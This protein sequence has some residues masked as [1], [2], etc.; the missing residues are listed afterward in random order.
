MKKIKT[1]DITTS[2]A[3]PVKQGTLDHLQSA[4]TEI[5]Q[6]F[7]LQMLSQS[8]RGI[9]YGCIKTQTGLNWSITA[10]YVYY[11]G[12]IYLCDAAN[13]TLGAGQ[14][15]WGTITTTNLTATNADPVEFSN[16]LTYNVHE[17]RKIVWS[18]AT[19]GTDL[20]SIFDNSRFGKFYADNYSAGKLTA[21]VGTWTIA[22]SADWS[23]LYAINGRSITYDIQITNYT[24]NNSAAVTLYLELEAGFIPSRDMIAIGFVDDTGGAKLAQLKAVTG[25]NLLEIKILSGIDNPTFTNFNAATA[26]GVLKGQITFEIEAAI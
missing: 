1:T 7:A 26:I 21:N 9:I 22:S 5:I 2:A 18:S 15:I 6:G 23:V 4:Y 11:N 13:G 8:Q 24:N 12:E 10:G 3:M 16:G 17:I 20:F 25:S 19:S 14:S